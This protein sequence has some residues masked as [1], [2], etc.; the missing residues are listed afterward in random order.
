MLAPMLVISIVSCFL[1]RLGKIVHV[2]FD[3]ENEIFLIKSSDQ[4]LEFEVGLFQGFRKR[5]SGLVEVSFRNEKPFTFM[6]PT[7][8]EYPPKNLVIRLLEDL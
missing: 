6:P 4:K 3:T 2:W 5:N 7:T 8:F 1:S